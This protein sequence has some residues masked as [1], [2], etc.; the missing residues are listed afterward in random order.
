MIL[1]ATL[2][3]KVF[4]LWNENVFFFLISKWALKTSSKNPHRKWSHIPLFY[5]KV[6]K[7]TMLIL[8]YTN[9]GGGALAYR[10]DDL[11]CTDMLGLNSLRIFFG[12][13]RTSIHS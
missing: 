4:N 7:K 6:Q 9:A 1:I 8:G 5:Y 13:L 11:S 2:G 3:G 12:G 10:L